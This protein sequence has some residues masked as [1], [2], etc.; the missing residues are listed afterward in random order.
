MRILIDVMGL[1]KGLEVM[2]K[3]SLDALDQKDFTPIFVGP[4]DQIVQ[5]IPPSLKNKVE[6]IKANDW[7]KNDESPVMAIRKKKDASMVRALYALKNGEADGMIS[8]GSTGAILAGASLIVGRIKN[9]DRAAITLILPGFKGRTIMLDVGA[10]VD[11]SADLIGQFAQMGSSYA[12]VLLE[13]DKPRVGLLNIGT[14]EGKGNDLCI[15]SYD[16]LK[17]SDLNFIGNI[18]PYDLLST[19]ADVLVTD[20]FTGNIALKTLEGTTK[21]FGRVLKDI[22]KRSFLAKVG[23]GLLSIEGKRTIKVLEIDKIG[24]AP[25]LG[26]K[27]PIF[28][29]HGSSTGD[30]ISAGIVQLIDFIEKDVIRDI[31]KS[32]G[33]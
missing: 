19:D 11:I 14:E 8:A 6:I 5:L 22:T 17:E 3:S 7:I 20:G 24:A 33:E 4:E 23:V 31:E 16:L 1:D 30:Q 25:L 29:A 21:T 28:K 32:M 10:N 18:E 12:K 27:K 15:R 2:I 26:S 13:T 9:I